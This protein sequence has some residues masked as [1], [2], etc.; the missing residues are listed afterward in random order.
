MK[1]PISMGQLLV[2]LKLMTYHSN[3]NEMHSYECVYLPIIYTK[4]F[5]S[6]L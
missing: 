1:Q 6:L 2:K 5:R 4:K 3:T